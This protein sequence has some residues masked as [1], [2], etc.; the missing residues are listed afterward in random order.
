M[1]GLVSR[2]PFNM[3]IL[4]NKSGQ[5]LGSRVTV[6]FSFQLFRKKGL[7]KLLSVATDLVLIIVLF[8]KKIISYFMS[9][10]KK[11]RYY[12]HLKGSR[13]NLFGVVYKGS[14]KK[15]SWLADSSG[16]QKPFE[17]AFKTESLPTDSC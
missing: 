17:N 7:S 16:S 5:P 11:N 12:K 15:W 10:L 2:S 6:P 8:N 13:Q 1:D 4:V 14:K 9:K 3:G